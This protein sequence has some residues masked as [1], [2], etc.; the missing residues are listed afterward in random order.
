MVAQGVIGVLFG[1]TL[2][3]LV[4]R[5][6]SSMDSPQQVTVKIPFC[7]A[8]QP[9]GTEQRSLVAGLI[10]AL[11]VIVMSAVLMG[12]VI[13]QEWNLSPA[14]V[15][16]PLVLGTLVV[17]FVLF[18]NS[19]LAGRY[20]ARDR[21]LTLYNVNETFANV[22]GSRETSEIASFLQQAD[23]SAEERPPWQLPDA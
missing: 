5:A 9:W 20:R 4:G 21:S 14:G 15:A 17:G 7:E 10:T 2:G 11:T 3:A 23:N 12:D 13:Q 19:D 22:V 6:I 18:V 1:V 16:I 8:H